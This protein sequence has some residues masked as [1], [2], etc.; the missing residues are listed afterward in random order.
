MFGRLW[1]NF[2]LWTTVEKLKVRITEIC[3]FPRKIKV[4]IGNGCWIASSQKINIHYMIF[5]CWL[6][7]FIICKIFAFLNYSLL[8]LENLT[9]FL[10]V[11]ESNIF[12]RPLKS[13]I[14]VTLNKRYISPSNRLIPLVL[15]SKHDLRLCVLK[16][17]VISW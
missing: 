9:S 14:C 7:I 3:I 5:I 15:W 12:W 6:I 11:Q 17:Q 1:C 16:F 4:L 8:G 13:F 10:R 2:F